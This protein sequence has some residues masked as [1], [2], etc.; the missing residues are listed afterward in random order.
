MYVYL[1]ILEEKD[2]SK[3][4]LK[5]YFKNK[6]IRLD[7]VY[8]SIGIV[9]L[10]SSKRLIASELKYITNLELDTKEYKIAKEK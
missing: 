9:K 1:A 3:N 4:T 2:V 10:I 5:K 8:N 6:D 7:K